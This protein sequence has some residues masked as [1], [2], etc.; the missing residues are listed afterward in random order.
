MLATCIMRTK[1]RRRRL[2]MQAR[3]CSIKL[4]GGPNSSKIVIILLCVDDHLYSWVIIRCPRTSAAGALDERPLCPRPC[5]MVDGNQLPR[6]FVPLVAMLLKGIVLPP[7][8]TNLRP[9]F[10]WWRP[11]FDDMWRIPFMVF[12]HRAFRQ[13]ATIHTHT[14]AALS[15]YLA[16]CPAHRNHVAATAVSQ[17]GTPVDLQ[18]SSDHRAARLANYRKSSPA[19]GNQLAI[20]GVMRTCAVLTARSSSWV[21]SLVPEHHAKDGPLGAMLAMLPSTSLGHA[22]RPVSPGWI[23]APPSSWLSVSRCCDKAPPI[24][25]RC[26]QGRGSCS[27]RLQ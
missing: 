10:R 6:L 18:S 4:S 1:F 2:C 8:R 26:W 12:R 25:D 13:L 16:G 17:L 7:F 23:P 27:N 3:S 14:D 19:L 21:H 5:I 24:I 9:R 22:T 15:A 20:R 11:A